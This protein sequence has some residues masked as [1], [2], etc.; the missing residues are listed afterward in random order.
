MP[1][2]FNSMSVPVD[3]QGVIIPGNTDTGPLIT[4]SAATTT[5]TSADQVNNG[6][7]GV[8][9]VLVTTAIG[10]GNI[11]LEIDGKDT[12]S[13]NYYAILTG[14]AVSSNTTNVY[15]VYPGVAVTA[16]VSASDVLPKTWRVKVTANSSNPTTYTVG[17][18]VIV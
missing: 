6:G 10:T 9:V 8:K 3:G 15:T 4:A 11:T 17:A 13:G 2:P 14:A 16:N 18:S 5:Q 1:G 7:C 12:A